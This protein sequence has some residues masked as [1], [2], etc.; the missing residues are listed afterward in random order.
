MKLVSSSQQ[1][2]TLKATIPE[3]IRLIRMEVSL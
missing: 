2:N 1:D 3:S